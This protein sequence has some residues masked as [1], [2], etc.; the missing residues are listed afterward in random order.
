VGSIS[1]KADKIISSRTARIKAH[2][3]I[4]NFVASSLCEESRFSESRRSWKEFGRGLARGHKPVRFGRLFAHSPCQLWASGCCGRSRFP[5]WLLWARTPSTLHHEWRLPLA[6]YNP[7]LVCTWNSSLTKACKNLA[8]CTR[9]ATSDER[10]S[11]RLAARRCDKLVQL[12]S[13]ARHGQ[14]CQLIL[15]AQSYLEFLNIE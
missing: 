4:L 9:F 5:S 12:S 15:E 2:D 14:R 6:N 11:E 3:Q 10:R 8:V 7:G 1:H 13:Q